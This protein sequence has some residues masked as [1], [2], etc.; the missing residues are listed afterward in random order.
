MTPTQ[1]ILS[2]QEICGLPTIHRRGMF[3]WRC[4][5]STA[6]LLLLACVQGSYG[7]GSG[8]APTGS[9]SASVVLDSVP[10]MTSPVISGPADV[11]TAVWAKGQSSSTSLKIAQKTSGVNQWQVTAIGESG[12]G[13]PPTVAESSD[14]IAI[15][16][17][18]PSGGSRRLSRGTVSTHRGV[19]R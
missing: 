12:L 10:P 5:A 4:R 13:L 19:R 8:G 14:G 16:G 7:Q 2:Q 9:W 17:M 6:A 3:Q 11:A 18:T 15:A 1:R